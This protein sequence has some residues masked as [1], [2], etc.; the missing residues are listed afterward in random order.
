MHRMFVYT[1][2]FDKLWL[3]L[4]K[5]I[6][7]LKEIEESLLENPKSGKVIEKTNGLRKLRW[8]ISGK[9]KS[10]GIRILYVDYEDLEILFFISLIK[11]NEKENIN[12]SDK[13]QFGKLILQ[14]KQN[15]KENYGKGKNKK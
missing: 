15:L 8:N 9:G 3:S 12:E 14:I 11:K 4:G 1:I 5:S 6:N 13:K 10:G 7:E 2:E